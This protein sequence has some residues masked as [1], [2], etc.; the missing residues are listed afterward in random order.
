MACPICNS[1]LYEKDRSEV[2]EGTLIA[3]RCS[4]PNCNYFDYKKIPINSFGT[5]TTFAG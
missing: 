2:T 4:N 5:G 3:I 1:D